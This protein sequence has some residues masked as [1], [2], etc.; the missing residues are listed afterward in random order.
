MGILSK[1]VLNKCKEKGIE[2]YTLNKSKANTI[3]FSTNNRRR[4]EFEI[5]FLKDLKYRISTRFVG[6]KKAMVESGNSVFEDNDPDGRRKRF[7][8]TLTN[9]VAVNRMIKDM[10]EYGFSDTP[11]TQRC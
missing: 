10:L 7:N 2:V 9:E 8:V 3:A 6:Y 4:R 5:T 11:D 1:E